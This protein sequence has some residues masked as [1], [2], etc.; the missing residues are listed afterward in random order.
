LLKKT[1]RQLKYGFL[2]EKEDIFTYCCTRMEFGKK[3]KK[4]SKQDEKSPA[5]SQ[6]N[7]AMTSQANTAMTSQANKA[8]TSQP[9]ILNYTQQG[10]GRKKL[11][12]IPS[13][14]Q[15]QTKPVA[16]PSISGATASGDGRLNK[17][18]RMRRKWSDCDTDQYRSGYPDKCDKSNLKAN[19][20]FYK[21]KIQSKPDGDYIDA[22]HKSWL[23]NYSLLERHHGFIQWLFPIRESGMNWSAQE[24]QLHEAEAI[25]AD[26][27]CKARFVQSY[28]LML[29]FYGMVLS[30]ADRGWINRADNWRDRFRHLNRSHHNYLRITRILKCLGELGY[31]HYKAP[32]C[33]FV[34]V[35]A[36][37]RG[38][39]DNCLGSC[40][41]YWIQTVK[42]DD[43]RERLHSLVDQLPDDNRS[44]ATLQHKR[45][46][47]SRDSDQDMMNED[48]DSIPGSPN[49]DYLYDVSQTSPAQ[50]PSDDADLG[51][52]PPESA[53]LGSTSTQTPPGESPPY[54]GLENWVR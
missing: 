7:K 46:P 10:Q 34:I 41:D 1:A 23:G 39:L 11:T 32:F 33:E 49:T 29:D 38:T 35:E 53:D 12:V 9:S 37:D 17:K 48:M 43:E 26:P 30:D 24:L 54:N 22:I 27:K 31:E 15:K 4:G 28:R 50:A 5:P 42:D 3:I 45:L 18:P 16:K 36:V 19:L 13:Q 6:A 47:T 20:E 14:D 51:Q 52:T 44:A 25:C 2:N 8:M 40:S 21:N